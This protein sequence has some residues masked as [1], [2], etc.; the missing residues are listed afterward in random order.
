MTLQEE[1][2]NDCY[3]IVELFA[4]FFKDIYSNFDTL[5]IVEE[6]IN[7]FCHYNG[8]LLFPFNWNCS[9]SDNNIYNVIKTL[10]S[11]FC[12]G[13]DGIHSYFIKNCIA[14]LCKPLSL[15]FN[16]SIN[17]G[18]IPVLWK[19]AFITPI[20]KSGTRSEIK[21]YRPIAILSCIP[22]ILDKYV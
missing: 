15:L 22:K 13:S 18:T 17:H 11:S 19:E 20:F 2:G 8:T 5:P 21:N 10:D 12:S 3:S 6:D 16:I 7:S 9:I 1:V 4:K 14:T